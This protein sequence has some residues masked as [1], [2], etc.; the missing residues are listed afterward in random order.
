MVRAKG[1][2]KTARRG[3]VLFHIGDKHARQSVWLKGKASFGGAGKCAQSVN[4][5]ACSVAKAL[6]ERAREQDLGVVL[7]NFLHWR[8][9]HFPVGGRTVAPRTP[10]PGRVAL[11]PRRIRRR[12]S[13]TARST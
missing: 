13:A 7:R 12:M 9:P 1:R 6:P 3:N 11:S 5:D 10:I 2:E 8:A 4:F